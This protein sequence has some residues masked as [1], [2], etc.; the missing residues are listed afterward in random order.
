[1]SGKAKIYISFVVTVGTVLIANEMF[2]WE[3]QDV[4]RYLAY[5]VLAVLTSRLKLNLPGVHGTLSLFFI[6]VL[7]GILRLS[8]PE[9][10]LIGCSSALVQSVWHSRVFPKIYQVAFN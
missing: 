9:T 2:L 6:F 10:V 1:M 5:L 4:L 7:F 3:S 8:L